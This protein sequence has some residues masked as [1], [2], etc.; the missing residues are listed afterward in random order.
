MDKDLEVKDKEPAEK[1]TDELN[2]Q[3]Q[4]EVAGGHDGWIEVVGHN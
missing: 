2:S 3:E 4:E 1:T